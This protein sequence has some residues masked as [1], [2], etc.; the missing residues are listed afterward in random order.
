MSIIFIPLTIPLEYFFSS[1]QSLFLLFYFALFSAFSC[2]FLPEK[3][4]L[5]VWQNLIKARNLFP[6]IQF[7]ATRI[8]TVFQNEEDG[9]SSWEDKKAIKISFWGNLQHFSLHSSFFMHSNPEE[10]FDRKTIP[11]WNVKTH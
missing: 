9:V 5:I 8:S 2:F 1:L 7:F 3:M 11:T 4:I 10:Q 6:C